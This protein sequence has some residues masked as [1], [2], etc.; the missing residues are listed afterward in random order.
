M[1][2]Y[3]KKDCTHYA[4]FFGIPCY[5]DE[6]KGLLIGRNDFWNWCLFNVGLRVFGFYCILKDMLFGINHHMFPIY[7]TGTI[8]HD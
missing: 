1:I 3:S 5:T 4:W 8:K 6:E 7:I 2:T